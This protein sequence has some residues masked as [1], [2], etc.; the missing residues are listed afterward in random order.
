M[1]TTINKIRASN[2][3]C[4]G[5]G[6]GLL[7][8]RVGVDY[9]DDKPIS[10]SVVLDAVGLFGAIW[11]IRTIDGYEDI[12]NEFNAYCCS[13]SSLSIGEIKSKYLEFFGE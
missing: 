6:L 10:M 8:D 5:K 11:A 13:N 4:D 7:I 12:K 9:G 3:P 2:P 1:Y